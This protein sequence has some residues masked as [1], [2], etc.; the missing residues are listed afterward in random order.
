MKY[1][2]RSVHTNL[3]NNTNQY[4][5]NVV[6]EI[7]SCNAIFIVFLMI[8]FIFSLCCFEDA[9]QQKERTQTF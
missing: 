2:K 4:K 3:F 8:L 1:E 7:Q 6:L 9:I 5:K